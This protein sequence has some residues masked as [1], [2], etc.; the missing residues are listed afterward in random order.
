MSKI[1]GY[2]H[3][4]GPLTG[5]GEDYGRRGYGTTSAAVQDARRTEAERALEGRLPPA[6]QAE[7]AHAKRHLASLYVKLEKK[8]GMTRMQLLVELRRRWVSEVS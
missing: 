3:G 2:E 7:I 6:A 1:E 5:G 8:R 4:E